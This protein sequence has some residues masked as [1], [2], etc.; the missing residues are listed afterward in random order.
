MDLQGT[1]Q[2]SGDKS[3]LLQAPEIC[4]EVLSP[5][6][7]RAEMTEKKALYFAAGAEKSG[8]VKRLGK[9]RSTAI[10]I[11]VEP[12]PRLGVPEFPRR[13]EL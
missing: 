1:P 4:I 2:A 3:C 5:G 13:I 10:Q 6:N 9:W 7:S 11:P 12:L 8:S